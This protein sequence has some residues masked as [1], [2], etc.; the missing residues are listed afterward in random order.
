MKIEKLKFKETKW[1]KSIIKTNPYIKKALQII[2]KF[3][4]RINSRI[5]FVG[6][7]E[8]INKKTI[9]NTNHIFIPSLIW[10]NGLLTNRQN[11]IQQITNDNSANTDK[12]KIL[13]ILLKLKKKPNLI[14]ILDER[15]SR[16]VIEEG[17]ISRIPI[18][19]LNSS[20]N[21]K[22]SSYKIPQLITDENQIYLFL[23]ILQSILKIRPKIKKKKPKL[24]R[25][26]R[27]LRKSL[28]QLRKRNKKKK[29]I[30]NRSKNYYYKNKKR[31]DYSKK[32]RKI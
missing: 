11:T 17:Y 10:K 20:M 29:K 25:W 21:D 4:V 8:D 5:L 23:N 19:T 6:N 13:N 3:H 22:K 24:M 14:V 28:I 1:N 18:V 12:F 16:N 27:N 31:N 30:F 15:N 32:K 7:S 9:V 26:C 2:F